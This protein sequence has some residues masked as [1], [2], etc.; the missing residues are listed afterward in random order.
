MEPVRKTFV[1]FF[2]RGNLLQGRSTIEVAERDPAKVAVPKG[3][4]AFQFKDAFYA[5]VEN[6]GEL[7]ELHSEPLDVSGTYYVGGT[8]MTREDV[9]REFPE[10]RVLLDNMEN[11]GLGR[12]ILIAGDIFE[13][14]DEGDTL[15][16][17]PVG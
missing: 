13:P 14:F 1:T 12:V 6:N 10:K 2:H 7:V 16:P 17:T 8:V 3:A 5:T 15:L 4:Y 11:S 9:V